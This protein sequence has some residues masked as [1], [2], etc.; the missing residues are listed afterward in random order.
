MHLLHLREV[1]ANIVL[2]RLNVYIFHFTL[3]GSVIGEQM[4]LHDLKCHHEEGQAT[5]DLPL[6][7]VI[8]VDELALLGLEGVV[9]CPGDTILQNEVE[10]S[11]DLS[12][13]DLVS[14]H[15]AEVS[16]L[17]RVDGINLHV[18]GLG[19]GGRFVAHKPPGEG[20][21]LI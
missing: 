8:Y 6:R 16:G 2:A 14:I 17:I 5:R 12:E 3:L 21:D 20:A 19:E 9:A 11:T 15:D 18:R 13:A 10:G 1:G 4:G 7:A